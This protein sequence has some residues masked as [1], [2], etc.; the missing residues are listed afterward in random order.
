MDPPFGAPT[1]GDLYRNAWEV[2]DLGPTDSRKGMRPALIRQLGECATLPT[3]GIRDAMGAQT[4][5]EERD[6]A[7]CCTPN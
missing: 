2:G 4:L 5:K 7:N 1:S 6:G 3:F